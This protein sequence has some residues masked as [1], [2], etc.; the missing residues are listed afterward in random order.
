MCLLWI[1]DIVT[2]VVLSYTQTI[3]ASIVAPCLRA[4]FTM[5]SKKVIRTEPPRSP[6]SR[7]SFM[8][9]MGSRW[10][11][12]SADCLSRAQG[13]RICDSDLCNGIRGSR[14][15]TMPIDYF[16]FKSD[17]KALSIGKNPGPSH[18]DGF[19]WIQL[20][21]DPR[22]GHHASKCSAE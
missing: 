2:I 12:E 16:Q 21:C 4:V 7:C 20:C 14:Y 10:F 1:I 17:R 9:S 6:P 22:S 19:S 8:D 18:F 15:L 11:T 5:H 13:L 3:A